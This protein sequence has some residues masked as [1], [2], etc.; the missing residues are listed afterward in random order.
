VKVL[1]LQMQKV[2]PPNHLQMTFDVSAL[3]YLKNHLLVLH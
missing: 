1:L 3:N 2:L